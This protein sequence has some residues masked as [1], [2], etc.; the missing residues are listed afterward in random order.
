MPVGFRNTETKQ[1]LIGNHADIKRLFADA[2]SPLAAYGARTQAS[3]CRAI[4]GL[5]ASF[6]LPA[7]FETQ[8]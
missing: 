4:I 6:L 1:Q 7:L 5:F 8:E 2:G 3:V